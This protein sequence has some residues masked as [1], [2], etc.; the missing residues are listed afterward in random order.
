MFTASRRGGREV[1]RCEAAGRCRR[2]DDL[3][4]G[5][6]AFERHHRLLR[7]A[8]TAEVEAAARSRWRA[9]RGPGARMIA[10][11]AHRDGR[12]SGGR[13][14][15]ASRWR[16]GARRRLA[17]RG[18]QRAAAASRRSLVLALADGTR[19]RGTRRTRHR[20]RAPPRLA[21]RD[22]RAC[23]CGAAFTLLARGDCARPTRLLRRR[24]TDELVA[25]G[26]RRRRRGLPRRVPGRIPA[27]AR[28][29]RRRPRA[30]DDRRTDR[31]R[32]RR[33]ALSGSTRRLELLRG[34][35]PHEEAL[36]RPTS[37]PARYPH[38][39][40]GPRAAWRSLRRRRSTALGRHDEAL[41]P[42]RGGARAG[43]RLGRTRAR[44]AGRCGAAASS[45]RGRPRDLR[46]AVSAA[47]GRPRGSSA[48]KALAALG[49]ACAAAAARPTRAS[50]CARR[51]S[52]PSVRRRR[53]RRDVRAELAPPA[54]GRAATPLSGVRR[55]DRPASAGSPSSRP[56]GHSNRD[57]AQ[58]PVRHPEDRRGPPL[59]RLPQARI[60][61]RRE[62]PGAH[63]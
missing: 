45:A 49:P 11:A 25:V 61:S 40:A 17:A 26:L 18:R 41:A 51:S 1:A 44:S 23:T 48:R 47:R 24:R 46:E 52:S 50:R 58:A 27:R 16:A 43:P 30:A 60:G 59:E 53:S 3:R 33:V 29:P 13:P 6:P 14:T 57:I 36:G 31:R 19:R 42:R 8:A 4:D 21:V 9:G 12:T 55:A 10:A 63:G 2:A 20:R 62:L 15:S 56:R 38:Y 54:S 35:G 37:S 28:R 7:R 34:R 5:A 22:R 32:R 39:A